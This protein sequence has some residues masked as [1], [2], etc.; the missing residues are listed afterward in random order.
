MYMYIYIRENGHG[1]RLDRRK[2]RGRMG[3]NNEERAGGGD[4][5]HPGK[6]SQ[7]RLTQGIVTS[8]VRTAAHCDGWERCGAGAG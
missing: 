3:Q 1:E 5:I 4:Q 2:R 7:K 6:C 8:T